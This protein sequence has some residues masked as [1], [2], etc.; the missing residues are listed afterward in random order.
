MKRKVCIFGGNSLV[1]QGLRTSALFENFEISFTSR[2]SGGE[3][4]KRRIIFEISEHAEYGWCRA[5]DAVIF[6]SAMTSRADC[7]KD[8]YQAALVNVLA[9]IAAAKEVL[10]AKRHFV[11]LSTQSVLGGATPFLESDAPYQPSDGYAASKACTEV[12]LRS[13]PN[14]ETNLAILRPTKILDI[15]RDPVRSWLSA[16]R[17]G[18][19]VRAFDDYKMAPIT[20]SQLLPMLQNV[21]TDLRPGVFQISANKEVSYYE[22]AVKLAQNLGAS[23]DL[24]KRVSGRR[25]NGIVAA[26]PLHSS[27]ESRFD[28]SIEQTI[29]SLL[30]RPQQL[31]VDD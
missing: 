15:S 18:K 20:L 19:P 6:C 27:L 14:A 17:E 22:F 3:N 5:F 8:P 16:L 13:L 10:N 1:G 4:E 24:V 28:I 7:V 30:D 25:T 26:S 29:R 11:F 23:T 21:L 9:P 2:R 12:M 31:G